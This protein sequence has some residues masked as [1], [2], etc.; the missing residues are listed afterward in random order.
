MNVELSTFDYIWNYLKDD[1]L[2]LTAM[3]LGKFSQHFTA[4]FRPNKVPTFLH[5]TFPQHFS[6]PA[7]ISASTFQA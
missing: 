1:P 4:I 5:R 6:T 3:K 7:G 2:T